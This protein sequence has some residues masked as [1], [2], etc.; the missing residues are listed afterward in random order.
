MIEIVTL[1]PTDGIRP[2]LRVIEGGHETTPPAGTLSVMSL[3]REE[4]LLTDVDDLARFRKPDG[5]YSEEAINSVRQNKVTAVKEGAMPYAVS[6]VEHQW[7]ASLTDEGGVIWDLGRTGEETAE[8]GFLFYRYAASRARG[9]V[10]VDYA[11]YNRKL[12]PG[13]AHV[14]IAPK[15]TL[16]DASREIA[17][18]EG[19][20]ATDSIQINWLALNE[21]GIPVAAK[22]ASILVADVPIEAWVDM[23]AD[24]N[25][26]FEKAISV[27]N[28]KSAL[29]VMK[30]FAALD[31]PIE[32]LHEGPI[33]ILAAVL[34]YIKDL[35]ARQRV[36]QHLAE[37]RSDQAEM[38]ERALSPAERWLNFDKETEQSLYS[39]IATN[40]LRQ[41][42]ESLRN[43]WNSEDQD[44]LEQH[45]TTEGDNT[46]YLMTRKLAIVLQK[47]ARNLIL[48][49]AAVVT[50]NKKVLKQMSAEVAARIYQGEIAVSR[51]GSLQHM[52]H[53]LTAHNN[54]IASQNVK[55]GGGCCGTIK[56]EFLNDG[57]TESET[58]LSISSL[59]SWHGGSV[60]D[61]TCVNCKRETEVG[62]KN[63]CKPCIEKPIGSRKAA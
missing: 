48:T 38:H 60:K 18:A 45:K 7:V 34:P 63:W 30:T 26:I 54:L 11:R 41:F 21:D 37:F 56:T 47:A 58:S 61:G 40:G 14:M 32:R 62:V 36:S 3:P 8:R 31:L 9:H 19:L 23:L 44:T 50:H 5:S 53:L 22:T 46:S 39:G 13:V 27:E 24:E 1:S 2:T 15:M 10:E 4:C 20:A 55:V 6:E 29:S 17:K 49:S 16:Q 35:E 57:I 59:E 51:A 28:P 25:N 43:N 52:A 12:R 42:I 33:T